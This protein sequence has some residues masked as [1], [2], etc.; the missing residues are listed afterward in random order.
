MPAPSHI[1]KAIAQDDAEVAPEATAEP[2]PPWHVPP[3]PAVAA[4]KATSKQ[5]PSRYKWLAKPKPPAKRYI[6]LPA[7][8]VVTRSRSRTAAAASD[9]AAQPQNIASLSCSASDDPLHLN[10]AVDA[11]TISEAPFYDD[12]MHLRMANLDFQDVSCTNA[13]RE[14]APLQ[15]SINYLGLVHIA[16]YTPDN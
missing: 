13:N 4:P 2:T 8:H 9:V 6:N 16:S 11:V 3:P 15:H 1:K 7:P 5:A 12:L 10:Y 14:W